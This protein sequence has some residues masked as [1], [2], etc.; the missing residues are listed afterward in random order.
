MSKRIVYSE[1]GTAD[2]LR[3][4]DGP[5]PVPGPGRVL[6][7]TEMIGVNPID[8]KLVAGAFARVDPAPFPGTPGWAA[9]GIIEALGDGVT[10]YAIGQ[11]V[12]LDSRA[13]L[14][15]TSGSRGG[16]FAEHVTVDTTRIVPRPEGVSIEQA[17]SLPSSAVAGYS[18]IQN[19][20][21]TSEDILLVHG[22]AG[23]VGSATV[24]IAIDR[25]AKVI[26]TAS[27]RNHD[28]LRSLGAT[29][30]AYGDGLETALRDLGAIT[31]SADAVGGR[32]SV[33]A[34]RGALDPRGRA[35]T[36]WG[37]DHSHA[38]GIP[39][40]RHPD[41][42]LEQAVALAMRGVLTVRIGETFPL[43]QAADALLRS[44]TP[45]SAGKILLAP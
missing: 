23:S 16:T 14:P 3:F 30:V 19:L 18:M 15:V 28:Y 2:V 24:Q 35:V 6:V 4:E 7:R 10:D 29:P 44:R 45:H 26:G 41:D 31:A 1:Y 9:T 42:E 25:G 33:S 5:L 21:I 11:A 13:R 32:E 39:W 43:A 17:A 22:A 37:D 20:G 40:V 8:W 34:T 36:A 27:P 12:I 38:A